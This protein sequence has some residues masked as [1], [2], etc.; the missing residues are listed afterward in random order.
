MESSRGKRRWR[1]S[2]GSMLKL[3]GLCLAAAV[4]L[5]GVRSLAC[6]GGSGCSARTVLLRSD[7]WR[8]AAASC[9]DQGCSGGGGQ[10]LQRRRRLLAEGPGS[11][12]PRCASKCG[13][14]SPCYPVHVA[15][16]P[17]VP[18]TTEY[19]PEAWRC[20][21]GNRLYMP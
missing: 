12:P 13:A 17:G 8:R 10:W 18:V 9:G 14:C 2:A 21:C 19:Y 11:Y 7:F 3:A 6:D 15:V 5:C 16:P 20:K 4:C 1:W